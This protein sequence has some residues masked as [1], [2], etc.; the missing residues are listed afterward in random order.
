MKAKLFMAVVLGSTLAACALQP[1]GVL[2]SDIKSDSSYPRPWAYGDLNYLK[3]P[4][5]LIGHSTG[6]VCS[7]NL[8]GLYASGDSSIDS[9]VQSALKNAGGNASILYDVKIDH[10]FTTYLGL[11][12]IFCTQ[13]SG[14]AAEGL[15]SVVCPP[16]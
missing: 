4:Y 7:T 16:K 9:A 13:V 1:K 12:S 5:K 14:I 2:Y 3:I 6:E 10:K 11:Y 15:P 8:L